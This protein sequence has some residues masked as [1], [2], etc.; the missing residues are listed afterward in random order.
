MELAEHY[1]PDH[2]L[3]VSYMRTQADSAEAHRLVSE[4]C[5]IVCTEEGAR[6]EFAQEAD[7]NYQLERI[8][9]GE[10][11]ALRP[12]QFGEIDFDLDATAAHQIVQAANAAY[13]RLPL[14]V[15]Q[16]FPSWQALAAALEA[17]PEL[18]NTSATP[19]GVS[20]SGGA[21]APPAGSPPAA[22][23]ADGGSAPVQP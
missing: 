22:G 10:R 17:N 14:A 9:R 11:P 16:R 3:P 12:M 21:E 19:E 23:T 4:S 7:I 5:A 13:D 20:P 15:R 2:A 18:F 8:L 1:V 6:Q